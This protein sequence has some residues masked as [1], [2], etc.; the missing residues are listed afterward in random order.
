MHAGGDDR[1]P[2]AGLSGLSVVFA[3]YITLYPPL[4]RR[5]M[6]TPAM[7]GGINKCCPGL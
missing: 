4:V 3:V 2:L 5:V 6:G 1:S 7:E